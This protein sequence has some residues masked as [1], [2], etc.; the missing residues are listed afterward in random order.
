MESAMDSSKVKLIGALLVIVALAAFTPAQAPP[1]EVDA[2]FARVGDVIVAL[3]DF[4]APVALDD[5]ALAEADA[6]VRAIVECDTGHAFV[7][8]G[9]ATAI[10]A[11]MA[12]AVTALPVTSA[13]A[14]GGSM[15]DTHPKQPVV[16]FELEKKWTDEKGAARVRKAKLEV[17]K[18]SGES[19]EEHIDRAE[20]E[21]EKWEKKGWSSV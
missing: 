4:G 12:S 20:R 18:R 1:Q 6:S 14:F 5:A 19:T 3:D 8:L 11:V 9:S 17:E 7:L 10:E 2:A 16:V 21:L 15:A 13:P